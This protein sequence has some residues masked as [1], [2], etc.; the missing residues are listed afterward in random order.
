M[1]ASL[2]RRR[3]WALRRSSRDDELKVVREPTHPHQVAMQNRRDC[4][5]DL[6][7]RRV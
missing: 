7:A 5:W 6:L 4:R 1:A 2:C 3:R